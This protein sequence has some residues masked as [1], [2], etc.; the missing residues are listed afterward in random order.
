ME[1]RLEMTVRV[2]PLGPLLAPSWSALGPSW[3]LLGPFWAPS[4]AV[5]GSSWR[6]LG[7]SWAGLG[8][9]VGRLGLWEA[10]KGDHTRI[11]EKPKE[12]LLFLASRS[13]LGEPLG[14]LLGRL[15]GLLGRLGA[16]LGRLG[17]LLG[18]LGPSWTVLEPSWDPLGPSSGPLGSEKVMRQHATGGTRQRPRN[19]GIWGPGP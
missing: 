13:S 7:P 3:S 10:R 6:R 5:L 19:T 12:R 16:I 9:R 14:A 17:A 4:W 8:G 18:R 2:P 11:R 15:G 1:E